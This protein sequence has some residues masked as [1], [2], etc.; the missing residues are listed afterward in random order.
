MARKQQWVATTPTTQGR[1]NKLLSEAWGPLGQ[2]AER[3]VIC[4]ICGGKEE[5]EGYQGQRPRKLFKPNRW[6]NPTTYPAR[7]KFSE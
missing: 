7:E 2:V 5:E 1:R 6:S 4:N 3:M